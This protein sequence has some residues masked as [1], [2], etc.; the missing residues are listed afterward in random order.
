MK[1]M[2]LTVC[3]VFLC[4]ALI[5]PAISE[6]APEHRWRMAQVHPVGSA[7][8]LRARE[9]AALVYERS[10]GRLQ[11]DVFSGGLLGD[12]TETFEMH[13]RGVLD[14]NMSPANANFDP[15]LNLAYYFPF[16]VRNFEEAKEVFHPDYGWAHRIITDLWADHNIKALAIIPVGMSGVSLNEVP[17]YYWDPTVSKGMR[18][19]VMPITPCQWVYEALGFIATPIPFAETY[20]AI[21][22]GIVEG[23]MGGSPFQGWQFRDVNRVWVQYNDYFETWWLSMYMGLWNNLSPE[24][25]EIIQ[26]AALEVSETQWARAAIGDEHYRQRLIDEYG[27]E[28]V[29]LTDEQLTVVADHVRSVVWPQMET[30]IGTELMNRILEESGIPRTW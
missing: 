11:V 18:V 19:R 20:S 25:Q 13:M 8:D 24:D 7:F 27:W 17:P 21:Q 10:G 30:L 26:A 15:R 12:W 14:M 5:A 3:A 28:I 6:A 16:L 22:T 23:Q 29:M 4:L 1:R 9:F 2:F